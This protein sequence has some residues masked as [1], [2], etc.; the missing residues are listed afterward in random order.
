MGISRF[1]VE[2]IVIESTMWK[3]AIL[4]GKVSEKCIMNSFHCSVSLVGE[5]GV[6]NF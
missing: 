1:I 2:R 4:Y 6:E 5:I 3:L